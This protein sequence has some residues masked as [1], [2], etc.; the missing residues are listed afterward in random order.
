VESRAPD[1]RVYTSAFAREMFVE[2]CQ[3]L[4]AEPDMPEPKKAL[5]RRRK[6]ELEARG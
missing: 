1:Q 4:L 5:V 6:A 3:A 2:G